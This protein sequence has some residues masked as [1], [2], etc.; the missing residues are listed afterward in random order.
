[1]RIAHQSLCRAVFAVAAVT[2]FSAVVRTQSRT[3]VTI[4]DTGVQ[5]ENITS[6]Q[7]GSVY[8]GSTA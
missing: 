3:E 2:S 5:A 7:D 6:S 1:M 4:N 8:F